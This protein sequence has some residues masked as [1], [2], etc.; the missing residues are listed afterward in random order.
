MIMQINARIFP[1]FIHIIKNCVCIE[2]NM[3]FL[4]DWHLMPLAADDDY[5]PKNWKICYFL[6]FQSIALIKNIYTDCG[7]LPVLVTD[8]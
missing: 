5:L 7:C 2:T 6:Q 4:S 1:I 8:V 3:V